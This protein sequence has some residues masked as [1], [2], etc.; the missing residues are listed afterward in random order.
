MRRSEL[1]LLALLSAGQTLGCTPDDGEPPPEVLPGPVEWNRD[2]VPPAD[3]A[4]S[5]ARSACDY[6]AGALPAETQ[7]ESR[8]YG[9]E[10]PIDNIVVL[11]MENRSFDHYFQKLPEFGQPDV[12]VA[13][14]N[15]T[16]PDVNG[17]PVAPFRDTELC[18]L[19]VNHEWTGTHDQINGGKMD[20]FFMTND[21]WNE[22]PAGANMNET[23]R[24]GNRALGYYTG[25]DLP[26]YYWLANEFAIGDRYFSSIAG[27]TWPNRMYLYAGSSFGAAHNDIVSPD[28]TIFD[29]LEQRQVSWKVYYSTTPGLAIFID[30]YLKL[31][32]ELEGRFLPITEYFADAAAGTLPSVAFV[33]PGIAREGYDQNDEHPPAIPMLGEQF[34]ATAIEALT[35]SPQWDKSAFFL[36]YDEHGGFYDHVVPPPACPPDDLTP[37]LKPGDTDAKFDSL[38]VRVPFVVVS[39]YA[40]KHYVDH[41]TYDHTSIVRFIEARFQIPAMTNRDANAEAPWEM[42][43]FENPPHAIPPTLTMPPALDQSK[44]DA[45]KAIFDP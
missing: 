34:V 23:L 41:R 3:T 43:D 6:A 35:K 45:C 18:I 14:P 13:P 30:K 16:N 39:P 7:G 25:E 8:P 33:D 20:G 4:A 44:L 11:M 15:Y 21:G 32:Q 38:G 19:D 1:V 5:T 26:F 17:M 31:K 42:F 10:I 2:V 27:P 12:D 28:K 37:K 9:N 36:T 40:K 29:Y 22:L 24:A